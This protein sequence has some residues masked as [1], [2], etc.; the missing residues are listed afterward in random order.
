MWNRSVTMRILAA[1]CLLLIAACGTAT[2]SAAPNSAGPKEIAVL[3][4]ANGK[5]VSAMA[6]DTIQLTLSSSY[7]N[8]AG[9]SAPRILRQDGQPKLLPR[10][11]SCP[12]T[13]GL[14]CTPERVDYTALAVGT[15][16]ISASRTSC[17]EALRCAKKDTHFSVT[18]IVRKS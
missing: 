14:G 3:D 2:S 5:T 18:V 8:V 7:W 6:G 15:A 9:S 4:A 13:P 1:C 10:P 17:G 16:V 12:P 11:A